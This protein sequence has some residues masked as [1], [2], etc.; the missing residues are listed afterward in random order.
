MSQAAPAPYRWVAGDLILSV[1]VQPGAKRTQVAGLHAGA[2]KI[3]LQARPVEGA[4]NAALIAFLAE[5][6]GLPRKAVQILQGESSREK[7]LRLQAP[8][9]ERVAAVLQS[10]VLQ[11]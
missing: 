7:R 2:V 6:F 1:H 10:W 3:R 11:A 8:A 5:Q 9:P 4:A